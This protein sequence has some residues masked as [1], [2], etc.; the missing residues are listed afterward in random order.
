MNSFNFGLEIHSFN[1]S[2]APIYFLQSIP[3]CP[4]VKGPFSE[5]PLKVA[6]I[7]HSLISFSLL[8]PFTQFKCA[9]AGLARFGYVI[10]IRDFAKWQWCGVSPT[11][12]RVYPSSDSANKCDITPVLPHCTR[13][14]VLKSQVSALGWQKWHSGFKSSVVNVALKSSQGVWFHPLWC[15]GP[16]RAGFIILL[17]L[18]PSASSRTPFWLLMNSYCDILFPCSA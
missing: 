8:C 17:H 7:L 13:S 2:N 14:G 9:D 10:R 3:R 16:Q 11:V 4:A 18:T 1:R 15:T 12:R 5:L 6:Q